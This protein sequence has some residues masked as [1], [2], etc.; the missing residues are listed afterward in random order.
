VIHDIEQKIVI[1]TA[2]EVITVFRKHNPHICGDGPETGRNFDCDGCVYDSLVEE[3]LD[4][5]RPSL[6]DQAKVTEVSRNEAN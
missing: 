4:I 3:L 6:P 1:V 5:V 2:T